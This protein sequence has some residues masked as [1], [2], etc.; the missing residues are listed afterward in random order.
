MEKRAVI[1]LSDLLREDHYESSSSVSILAGPS[2]GVSPAVTASAAPLVDVGLQSAVQET[3]QSSP[4]ASDA[5]PI[6]QAVIST[7]APV[8]NGSWTTRLLGRG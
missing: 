1:A 2:T 3:E 6:S 7:K 8:A 5:S 4:P